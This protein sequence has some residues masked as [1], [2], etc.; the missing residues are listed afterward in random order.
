MAGVGLQ[1]IIHNLGLF[2]AIYR[3]KL[4]VRDVSLVISTQNCISFMSR[5]HGLYCVGSLEQKQSC[6]SFMHS[7]LSRA[8]GAYGGGL[9]GGAEVALV[10]C[11]SVCGLFVRGW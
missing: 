9:D 1:T 7:G 10:M 5:M 2:Y 4:N 6:T 11:M 8:C 3:A